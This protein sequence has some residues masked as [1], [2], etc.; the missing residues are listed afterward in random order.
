MKK[1][2]LQSMK[3]SLKEVLH[4]HLHYK[5]LY[6]DLQYLKLNTI[7]EFLDNYLELAARNSKTTVEVLD[8][9]FEQEKKHGEAVA[10]E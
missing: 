5:R 7:E 9:L 8:Y 3:R 6:N 10:I 4:E 1:G 2:F